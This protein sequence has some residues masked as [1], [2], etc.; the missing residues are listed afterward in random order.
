[1]QR[2]LSALVIGISAY[3]DGAALKNPV[4]DADDVAEALKELGFNAIKI[5]DATSEDIDRGLES[6][7]DALNSSDVGL[8]YFAGHGMQIKGENYLNT[9]DTSFFDEISAKHSS[10]PLNQII[11]TMDSCSNSTNIIVLDACRNNPF[12]RAWNRG[13]EQSGLASV[14]TPRG[15]FMAFATS[16]G[17]VAKD[18]S[19]RNGS[20]TD[21]LLTHIN[22]QDVPIEDLF[23]RVR[24]TLSARTSGTQTSWEHTSL[25]GDFFFNMSVGR[26]IDE[27]SS[28]ALADSLY[29][30]RSGNAVDEIIKDLRVS[31]WYTQNPAVERIS[32]NDLNA[33]DNDSLFVL[34]RNIYQASCGSANSAT[35]F[36]ENFRDKVVDVNE[37]KCKCM[38]D[39]MLFEI[40]FNSKGE[41]RSDFKVSKFNT[42][43]SLNSYSKFSE[44]FSFLSEILLKYQS[45]FYLI[46]GKSRK[47]SVDVIS[48]KNDEGEDV[49]KEIHF[50][51]FNILRKTDGFESS[52]WGAYPMKLS[53]LERFL[54]EEMVI[55]KNQLAVTASFNEGDKALFPYGMTV[56]K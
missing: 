11:D 2:K 23:K 34:G 48:E 28:E 55:P 14:Y 13:P 37:D 3:P 26:I 35:D 1:M 12:V 10:F 47:V 40:F 51:G 56:K 18:G 45:R 24:N 5:T 52:D 42:V 20:F 15:T 53:K 41:L 49:V 36:I 16:P 30:L 39:G 29:M 33:A 4:N 25:S 46:P 50:Q 54:S 44:S 6:F 31:N 19:G 27:Y 8:F 43:F 22:T 21:S 38:L 32:A 7:K 17:E 9:V